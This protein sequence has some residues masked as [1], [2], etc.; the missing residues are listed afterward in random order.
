MSKERKSYEYT[1]RMALDKKARELGGEG[2]NEWLM[3]EASERERRLYDGKVAS[4]TGYLGALSTHGVS[5]ERMMR[6]GLDGSGYAKY[7]DTRARKTHEEELASLEH[8]YES[9]V[10]D[11]IGDYEEHIASLKKKKDELYNRTMTE[12]SAIGVVNFDDAYTA[13]VNAGLDTKTAKLLA[14]RAVTKTRYRLRN[15][16]L[17][18]IVDESLSRKAAQA[19]AEALGLEGEDVRQ[20]GTYA[21]KISQA[22]NNSG[23]TPVRLVQ[24]YKKREAEKLKQEEKINEGS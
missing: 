19:Y 15:K 6:L 2:I 5:A 11:D 17:N 13:A 20:L 16:V 22:K 18:K 9:A 10:A 7:L 14:G 8:E 12:L 23:V 1:L 4:R 3:K 24:L 21:Y